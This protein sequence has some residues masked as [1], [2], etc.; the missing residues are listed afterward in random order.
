M[1]K[2]G[3]DIKVIDNR[4]K[5]DLT[6]ITLTQIIY[7]E[8][9]K[10]RSILPLDALKKLIRTSGEGI[11]DLAGRIIQPSISSIQTARDDFEK[12]ISRLI[13]KGDLGK[14]EGEGLIKDIKAGTSQM[15]KRID[16]SLSQ[17]MDLVKG[18]TILGK[19]VSSLEKEV[20]KLEKEIKKL[21]KK[22]IIKK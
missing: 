13:K 17:F 9:K 6:G 4:T 16:N 2:N 12:I 11:S 15:Q 5:E 20:A 22:G 10:Q 1:I 7:E 14:E 8:E 3:D 21:K 19:Q 18:V